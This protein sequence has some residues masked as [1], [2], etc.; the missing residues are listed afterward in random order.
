MPNED[1]SKI[2]VYSPDITPYSLEGRSGV[3]GTLVSIFVGPV[4][5]VSR[6][7]HNILVLP[8]NLRL[9]YANSLITVGFGMLGLGVVDLTLYKKWPL[10]VSQIPILYYAFRLRKQARKSVTVATQ[11]REVDID[12][13]EVEV[14]CN[15]IFQ[16]LKDITKG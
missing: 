15:T 12:V 8:A 9:D 1:R 4:R 5:I 6:V 16:D 11:K 14:L 7:T 2:K 10:I 13:K 3:F